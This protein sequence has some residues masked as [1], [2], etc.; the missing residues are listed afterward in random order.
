MATSLQGRGVGRLIPVDLCALLRALFPGVTTAAHP[1][2]RGQALPPADSVRRLGTNVRFAVV[3][4][5][6]VAGRCLRLYEYPISPASFP[7]DEG[8]R[9]CLPAVADPMG[10][11]ADFFFPSFLVHLLR[12]PCCLPS[13]G[14]PGHR[15]GERGAACPGGPRRS[16]RRVNATGSRGNLEPGLV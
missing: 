8:L 15:T 10:S 9:E 1:R 3:F 4:D 7:G 2:G 12:G 11:G 6:Y 16:G 14:K 5:N 13:E